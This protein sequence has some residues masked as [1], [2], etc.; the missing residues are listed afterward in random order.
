MAT[1]IQAAG[2]EITHLVCMTTVDVKGLLASDQTGMFPLISSRGMKYVCIFY[3]YDANFIKSVPIKSREKKELLQAYQEVYKFCEQRGFKPKLHKLDNETSKDV[4]DFV[5]AQ[6]AAIQYTPPDMHYTNPAERGLQTWKSCKKS[7]LVSLPKGFPITL[8]C[9]QCP[10][11]DLAV[12]IVRKCRQNPLLSAWA[13]MMGEYHFDATPIV[14]PG[15][16][17][18]M[19]EKPNRR[20][21]WGFN[22]KKAWY[23]GPCFKYY[24]NVHGWVPATGGKRINDTVR[25]KH[26]AIAVPQL[27]AAD[28]ILEAAKQ[29]D[30]AIAQQPRAAPMDEITAI[31][32]LRKVLLGERKETLPRNSVQRCRAAQTAAVK[33]AAPS[34]A[35]AMTTTTEAAVPTPAAPN[36]DVPAANFG[37]EPNYISDDEDSPAPNHR[38][39]RSKRILRQQRIDDQNELHCIVALVANETADV[40]DLEINKRRTTARGL[41]HANEALQM[42]EWALQDHFAGAIIDRATGESMEYRDLIKRDDLRATWERSF[43]NKIGQ[44]TQGI[45]DIEGTETI[46]FIPKSE[47]PQDRRK[48]VTYGR[49]VVSYRPQKT[50]K[51]RSCL[52]V[53]GDKINYPFDVSTPTSDLA[54]IKLL[55][56]SVLS[57]PGAKFF[58]LDVAN[59]YLKTPMKRPEFM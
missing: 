27:M 57:T 32:L 50:E 34:P 14:P 40:P 37:D 3:I 2:N 54:T 31:E 42:T 55:W 24:R 1:P 4:E 47:I 36:N 44:L 16:E 20:R 53:G 18:M 17:M 19:H 25:Y 39:R 43:A 5:A 6:Q 13:A 22:A 48:D 49:I 38:A 35:P 52:T 9:R 41:G 30:S 23:L 10:Q 7:S 46:Q 12:N 29:L 33:L 21:T 58:S 11:V 45:R 15:T 8:W 51:H 59:F 26:H 56:N 28:R